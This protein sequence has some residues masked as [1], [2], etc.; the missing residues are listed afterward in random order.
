MLEETDSR[1]RKW[2]NKKIEV[3]LVMRQNMSRAEGGGVPGQ[4]QQEGV[5]ER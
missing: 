1:L 2:P 5:N 3:S 4:S